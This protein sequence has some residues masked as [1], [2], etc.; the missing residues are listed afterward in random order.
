MNL[1]LL[2]YDSAGDG[3]PAKREENEMATY[4]IYTEDKNRL[5]VE[6]IV[7]QR[8]DSFTVYEARGHW[9]KVSEPTLIVEV[10]GDQVD[11]LAVQATAQAIKKHNKQEAV[12]IQRIANQSWLV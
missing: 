11:H 12:L 2:L 3:R 5:A 8:F 10:M 9:H 7:G 1:A 6:E 4:R